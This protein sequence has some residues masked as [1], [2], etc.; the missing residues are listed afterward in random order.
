MGTLR[1]SCQKTAKQ[2]KMLM[3]QSALSASQCSRHLRFYSC[4]KVNKPNLSDKAAFWRRKKHSRRTAIRKA[5][6]PHL[7]QHIMIRKPLS[8][9][10]NYTRNTTIFFACAKFH[11]C[12]T[13]LDPGKTSKTANYLKRKKKRKLAHAKIQQCCWVPS[14]LCG[15]MC[16]D[17]VC[18]KLLEETGVM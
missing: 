18:V 16:S 17:Q 10:D 14:M 12:L 5:V 6:Q 3:N 2:T 4:M 9:Y 8:S 15:Q 1:F 13:F 7:M 11:I